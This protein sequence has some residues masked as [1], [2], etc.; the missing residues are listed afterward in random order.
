VIKIVI[1][2]S[3]MKKTP[4][5]MLVFLMIVG[6]FASCSNKKSSLGTSPGES[7]MSGENPP[8]YEIGFPF[9]TTTDPT[10]VSVVNNVRAAVESA[11]GKLVLVESDLTAD[12]LIN[13]VAD[14]I[15]RGVNGILFMPASDSMLPTVD[16][17]CSEAGVY[18]GTM[19]RTIKDDAIRRQI[20][21]SGY[22]AGGANEDDEEASY[23]ITKTLVEKGVKNLCVINIAKGDTSSDL[24]DKGIA[25]A[26]Q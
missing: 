7:G 16:Q 13:N 11:G 25:R 24:R 8:A 1:G 10:F 5:R 4:V 18:Y 3:K 15:S 21:A 6:V 9:P 26:V 23:Q 19:F 2:G 12:S 17:M 20:Y 14:L 22:F